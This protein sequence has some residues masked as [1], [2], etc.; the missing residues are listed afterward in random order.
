MKSVL[1]CYESQYGYSQRYAQW[2]AEK[3]DCPTL[4]VAEVKK[5]DLRKA[6]L[7]VAGG[8]L[9]AG[10]VGSAAFV[11]RHSS[12]LEGKL[13]AFF[14]VGLA[15]VERQ[16]DMEALLKKA[17]PPQVQRNARFFFLRGGMD[18]SR[19]K[20]VHRMMMKMLY[21]SLHKTP[22]EKQT[23]ENRAFIETYGKQVDFTDF[24]ALE[25]IIQEIQRGTI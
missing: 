22:P 12:E 11:K 18:A 19:L 1:I 17:L 25:P 20:W 15:P 5:D 10:K 8:G 14:T 9:Y 3:L 7:V 6:D 16:G 13:A 23:A 2:M 24:S 21:Q 4:P